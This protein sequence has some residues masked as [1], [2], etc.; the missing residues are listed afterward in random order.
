MKT[1]KPYNQSVSIELT[2]DQV[3]LMLATITAS[4]VQLKRWKESETE[5]TEGAISEVEET[6]D[7]LEAVFQVFDNA[8]KRIEKSWSE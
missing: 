4:I 8:R 1:I 6:M 3:L 7:D 5:K 2:T